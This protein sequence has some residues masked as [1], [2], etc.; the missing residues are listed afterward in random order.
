[1]DITNFTWIDT[2]PV[3]QTHPN[4]NNDN[5]TGNETII[6]I[7]ASLFGVLGGAI[8]GFFVYRW[9]KKRRQENNRPGFPGTA[10]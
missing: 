3:N 5:K 6:G 2:F 8:C 10:S 1:M 9:I 4:D 7:L